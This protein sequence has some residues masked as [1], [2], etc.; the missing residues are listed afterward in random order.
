MLKIT[1]NQEEQLKQI[2]KDQLEELGNK[3]LLINEIT[4]MGKTQGEIL[5]E[6]LTDE[7]KR[8]I[9]IKKKMMIS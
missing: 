9:Q 3:K 5:N 6:L 2:R 1:P 4:K 8:K 7:E